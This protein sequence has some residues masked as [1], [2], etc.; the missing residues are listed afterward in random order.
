MIKKTLLSLSVL[1]ALVSS[2]CQERYPDLEDGLYAEFVTNKDTMVAK[3]YYKEAPVTVANFVALAEG[4]HPLVSEQYKGKRYYDSTTFHRVI[5]NFMIQGGDP[6][7]TGS[8]DPGYKF[9]D[10]FVAQLK[11]N[12]PGILSMANSGPNTNGSQFFITEKAT[13]FLDSYNP[14]G[15]L[16]DCENPRVSCHAVFGELVKGIEVQDSISNV[17]V[18]P[19]RNKPLEDVVILQLNI[20]RKGAEAKKF[21]APK[22]FNDELPRL[23]EIIAEQKAE[24]ARRAEEAMKEAKLKAEKACQDW[25]ENNKEL[26]GKRIESP[27]GMAMIFTK[28]GKGEKPDPSQRVNIDCAGYFE[29]GELF[30]T[31]WKDIAKKYG[32]YDERQDQGGGYAPFEMPYNETAGLVAGFREAMLNMKIGDRARVF[33]PYYLGYGEAGRPPVSPPKTNYVF[34]IDL[35]SVK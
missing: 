32:K 33:I 12:K 13:P 3:L 23:K 17:E 15:T 19:G 7:A 9:E 22:V 5:D 20:I 16:K 4:N 2:S 11:H 6:T 35:V 18:A 24:A 8:G 14:D 27:T 31:T 30:W 10:E 25:L 21:D 1:L 29:N 34:D 28:D 26:D